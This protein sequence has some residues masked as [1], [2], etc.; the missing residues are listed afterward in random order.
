MTW[1]R[2]AFEV[3]RTIKG[4]VRMRKNSRRARPRGIELFVRRPFP[5]ALGLGCGLQ[6]RN[7][8]S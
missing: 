8:Q 1:L 2:L 3:R 5:S 7:D 6:T 4:V